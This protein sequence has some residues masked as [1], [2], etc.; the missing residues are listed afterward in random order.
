MQAVA[1]GGTYWSSGSILVSADNNRPAGSA[2]FAVDGVDAARLYFSADSNT[3]LPAAIRTVRVTVGPGDHTLTWLRPAEAGTQRL[4]VD[5]FNFKPQDNAL[6]AAAL[7][8]PAVVLELTGSPD[9]SVQSAVTHDGA[10]A[11]QSGP[12]AAG[13]TSGLQILID[14]LG[15]LTYWWRGDLGSGSDAMASVTTQIA[16]PQIDSNGS[17][18]PWAGLASGLMESR[19]SDFSW[20][21]RRVSLGFGRHRISWWLAQKAGTPR[22][23]W[24]DNVNFTPASVSSGPAAVAEALD[25][26]GMTWTASPGWQR[27]Q[28][29]LNN[30]PTNDVLGAPLLMAEDEAWVQTAVTGPATLQ[31]WWD[32]TEWTTLSGTPYQKL[33]SVLI[34]GTELPPSASSSRSQQFEVPAG[35]HTVRILFHGIAGA[36]YRPLL[37]QVRVATTPGQALDQPTLVWSGVWPESWTGTSSGTWAGWASGEE[38]GRE[39]FLGTVHGSTRTG[40]TRMRTNAAGTAFQFDVKRNFSL[41]E[42][43]L[44]FPSLSGIPQLRAVIDGIV[45]WDSTGLTGDWTTVTLPMSGSMQSIGWEY[46]PVSFSP[47]GQ[48]HF[49]LDRI[50]ILTAPQPALP[51]FAE[52]LET[53]GRTWSGP[54]LPTRHASNPLLDDY[55]SASADPNAAPLATNV[56]GPGWIQFDYRQ[57]TSYLLWALD[58]ASTR[59]ESTSVSPL[60][61]RK[62]PRIFIPRGNRLLEWR[63]QVSYSAALNIVLTALDAVVFEPV[64]EIPVA[65]GLDSNLVWTTSGSSSN[66]GWHGI[67]LAGAVDGDAVAFTTFST[68]SLATSVTGPCLVEVRWKVEGTASYNTPTLQL[69]APGG[70]QFPA[71]SDGAWTISSCSLPAGVHPVSLA[72]SGTARFDAFT[73]LADQFSVTPSITLAAALNVPSLQAGGQGKVSGRQFADG[74][75][76]VLLAASPSLTDLNILSAEVNGPGELVFEYKIES[77]SSTNSGRRFTVDGTEAGPWVSSHAPT[78]RLALSAGP[79]TLRWIAG[80]AAVSVG[81]VSWTPGLPAWTNGLWGSSDKVVAWLTGS[82]GPWTA[83]PGQGIPGF[84][85]AVR[86]IAGT[87]GWIQ[88]VLS[89]A[90]IFSVWERTDPEAY[91]QITQTTSLVA[92]DWQFRREL[93]PAASPARSWLINPGKM[94]WLAGFNFTP[95]ATVPLAEALDGS[96]LTWVTSPPGSWAGITAL[97]KQGLSA[98]QAIPPAQG[99]PSVLRTTVT[100]PGLL[101]YSFRTSGTP[102]IEFSASFGL[103]GTKLAP[104][105]AQTSGVWQTT[106]IWIGNSGPPGV[107]LAGRQD[108]CRHFS[109]FGCGAFHAGHSNRI[110]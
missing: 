59:Q 14:G 35:N 8:L 32:A 1:A 69:I 2:V 43:P 101:R 66:A 23:L 82:D 7:G 91:N 74:R 81:S 34:N 53:P 102:L 98:A 12:A 88:P 75:T 77:S 27:Y 50:E 30:S 109:L 79:H 15:E 63:T 103:N 22:R 99:S 86:S 10:N 78:A 28:M 94:G 108:S 89:G 29:S 11:L 61:W 100:G 49:L 31:F 54:W 72:S 24:V 3:T 13:E 83:A 25:S 70:Q 71:R 93:Q 62:S 95:A 68:A 21:Q 17:G 52:V 37:D 104:P 85:D 20:E 18:F 67:P 47:E 38:P 41:P 96:A 19:I 97:S 58:G 65:Q 45:R 106:E 39:D 5:R 64:T 9:W 80:G 56:T 48:N 105:L 60:S 36:V 90:G 6:L 51:T 4:M 92:G 44:A 42:G 26:S 107:Q 40:S 87:Y 76:D 55:A 57:G 16:G 46:S 33:P 73:L 84:P 110:I